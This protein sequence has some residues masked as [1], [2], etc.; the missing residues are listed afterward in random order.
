MN[1]IDNFKCASKSMKNV[2]T[3]KESVT[4]IELHRKINNLE[5]V[6]G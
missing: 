4:P 2:K 5:R 6:L 3:T 1:L